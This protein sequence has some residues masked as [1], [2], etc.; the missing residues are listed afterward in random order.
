MSLNSSTNRTYNWPLNNNYQNENNIGVNELVGK[1]SS[2]DQM[3]VGNSS[4]LEHHQSYIKLKYEERNCLMQLYG[5]KKEKG[6]L[7]ERRVMAKDV[8][9]DRNIREIGILNSL[10]NENL[11]IQSALDN[12][13]V[14]YHE[15]IL[16]NEKRYVEKLEALNEFRRE[17]LSKLPD[18]YRYMSPEELEK[19]FKDVCHLNSDDIDD[20]LA[21]LNNSI[22]NY[23]SDY[24]D[25]KKKYGN[26]KRLFTQ[27]KIEME[28]EYE[29]KLKKFKDIEHEVETYKRIDEEKKFL[30]YELQEKKKQLDELLKKREYVELNNYELVSRRIRSRYQTEME[31]I[32]KNNDHMKKEFES[33]L[34]LIREKT[35][36]LMALREECK[37]IETFQSEKLDK[38]SKMENLI[39]QKRENR[40]KSFTNKSFD[41]IAPR[42]SD[43]YMRSPD[44]IQREINMII[45]GDTYKSI[46]NTAPVFKLAGDLLDSYEEENDEGENITLAE[47]TRSPKLTRS[48]KNRSLTKSQPLLASTSSMMSEEISK[49]IDSVSVN[50]PHKGLQT[51]PHLSKIFSHFASTSTNDDGL[52]SNSQH[53]RSYRY[54]PSPRPVHTS[55]IRDFAPQIS[56]KVVMTPPIRRLRSTDIGKLD[57]GPLADRNQVDLTECSNSNRK[58]ESQSESTDHEPCRIVINLPEEQ[59]NEIY[60][61]EIKLSHDAER[62]SSTIKS[63]ENENV[64]SK[65]IQIEAFSLV[66]NKESATVSNNE[67]FS[68]SNDDILTS[69][70]VKPLN[71]KT[72]DAFETNSGVI[73]NS[74]FDEVS[75]IKDNNIMESTKEKFTDPIE[76]EPLNVTNSNLPSRTDR[77]L[78]NSNNEGLINAVN[79][80]SFNL[81]NI[82]VCN[83]QLAKSDDL[84]SDDEIPIRDYSTLIH[85]NSEHN[86]EK[87]SIQENGSN[88][89][90]GFDFRYHSGLVQTTEQANNH[91]TDGYGKDFG[92]VHDLDIEINVHDIPIYLSVNEEILDTDYV[93]NDTVNCSNENLQLKSDSVS[94]TFKEDDNVEGK[95][96]ENRSS[97]SENIMNG[98]LDKTAQIYH[99]LEL[100]STTNNRLV[101]GHDIPI[102][103][104]LDQSREE[105]PDDLE[106]ILFE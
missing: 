75:T 13:S 54:F 26:L 53:N 25:K 102:H 106:D 71:I 1:K 82:Q 29:R 35:N 66:P 91:A 103:I 96:V 64:K 105:L 46:C 100:G 45:N 60:N 11:R 23:K 17:E 22:N 42:I 101:N 20:I 94:H 12:S 18:N 59:D 16:E 86:E 87:K 69:S 52:S 10:N 33:N 15:T 65:D 84:I 36:V 63:F 74:R 62:T 8:L 80:G 104:I 76:D 47:L 90:V 21:K 81:P 77:E 50:S 4:E 85:K 6:D 14:H 99:E 67:L 55:S 83:K 24:D 73:Y 9:I 49:I 56:R 19:L 78:M 39:K 28:D 37:D 30:E 40:R 31:G 38:I 34:E 61:D 95:N 72:K 92:Y 41:N 57:K 97:I 44:D 7:Y 43:Y 5:L 58:D 93:I 3:N 68:M 70:E 89:Q 51:S 98:E 88:I 27:S 2:K 79:E 32:L 48:L